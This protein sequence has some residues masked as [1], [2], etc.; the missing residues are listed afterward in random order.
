MKKIISFIV[1]LMFSSLALAA[2]NITQ[3][4]YTDDGYLEIRGSGFGSK[5]PVQPLVWMDF[6]AGNSSALSRF[7]PATPIGGTAIADPD[8]QGNRV[9]LFDASSWQSSGGPRGAIFESDRLYINLQRYYRFAINNPDL[10]GS[11]GG[12]GLNLKVIRLWT[13]FTQPHINNIYFGYQGKEGL[14]SGRIAAEY[15][16]VQTNWTGDTAPQK[17][18]SWLNEEFFYQASDIDQQNGVFQYVRDGI[19]ARAR[20]EQHRTS[21]R[22]NRYRQ[23]WF[24]QV[25]NYS[26]PNPLEIL[27]DNIYVDE[28][29]ARVLV[30]NAATPGEYQWAKMQIPVEW[31]DDFIR[32]KAQLDHLASPQVYLYV[33]N[34]QNQTQ[35]QG[36][37]LCPRCPKPPAI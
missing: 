25:S 14:S 16:G 36:Y 31:R 24:D 20:L 22:P 6:E 30:T 3:V 10:L 8:R 19:A 18:L 17:A 35:A 32:V 21:E 27:Y 4:T 9:L 1:A 37:R 29:Y 12:G 5:S 28:T 34:A 7:D 33:F 26:L 2:P 13:G 15:S 11:S 23:L